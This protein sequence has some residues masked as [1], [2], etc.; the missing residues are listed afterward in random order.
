MALRPDR[1]PTADGPQETRW[2]VAGIGAFSR[3]SVLSAWPTRNQGR[4]YSSDKHAFI[5]VVSL[6]DMLSA[7]TSN[8]SIQIALLEPALP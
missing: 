1:L 5:G 7:F 3:R 6:T 4:R 2:P 8:F